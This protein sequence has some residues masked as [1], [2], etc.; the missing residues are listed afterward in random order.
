MKLLSL[1][2]GVI[3]TYCI[4]SWV[5]LGLSNTIL[6]PTPGLCYVYLFLS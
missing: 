6:F 1:K 4:E 2:L 5:R 3:S